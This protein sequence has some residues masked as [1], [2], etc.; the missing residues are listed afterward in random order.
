LRGEPAP[1]VAVLLSPIEGVDV[2]A[3]DDPLADDASVGLR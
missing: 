1:L 3:V 2:E